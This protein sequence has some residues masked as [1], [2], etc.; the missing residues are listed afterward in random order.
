PGGRTAPRA[1]RRVAQHE[2]P[3]GALAR[4]T[5]QRARAGEGRGKGGRGRHLAFRV[6]RARLRH[7]P[8]WGWRDSARP[9][10][11]GR[12]RPRRALEHRDGRRDRRRRRRAAGPAAARP[13]RAAPAP[14]LP[15]ALFTGS[16]RAGWQALEVRLEGVA[17]DSEPRDDARV[18]VLEVSPPPS[19]VLLAYPRTGTAAF[20]PGH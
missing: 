14:T 9:G 7:A 11:G 5:R 12:R 19:V 17:G 1:A 10:P 20:S 8:P 16:A 18:F 13:H 15:P 2:R 6:E 4:G 3:R